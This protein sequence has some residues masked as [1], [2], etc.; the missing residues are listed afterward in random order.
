MIY[1]SKESIK[2]FRA[3][4][5]ATQEQLARW[6][7]V[8]IETVR[9]WEAGTFKPSRLALV[10]LNRLEQLHET[11]QL[12]D[13]PMLDKDKLAEIKRLIPKDDK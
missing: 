12:I 8:S 13:K 1:A 4:I 9:R 11:G 6:S 10:A 3:K 7:D 2:D 5:G